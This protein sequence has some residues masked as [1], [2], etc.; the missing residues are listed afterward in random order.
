M[1]GPTR[2]ELA[3]LL[4]ALPLAAQQNPPTPAEPKIRPAGS[5]VKAVDTVHENGA[6]LRAMNL[7][8]DV[9]PAFRFQA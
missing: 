5:L 4:G 6:K 3:A 2:R 8:M 1:R 7:P 9:E